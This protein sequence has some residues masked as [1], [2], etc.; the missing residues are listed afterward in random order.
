MKVLFITYLA[1]FGIFDGITQAQ[2]VDPAEYLSAEMEMTGEGGSEP[3]L[4]KLRLLPTEDQIFVIDAIVH[5]LQSISAGPA[6]APST[7]VGYVCVA[8]GILYQV[9]TDEQIIQA[10]GKLSN[11]GH[12]EPDAAEIL[13]SCEGSGGVE[14]IQ[15]LAEQRLPELESAINPKNDAERARSN[16]ILIPFHFLVV[17]L[18]GATNPE[19]SR[20]AKKLRDQVAARYLSENGKSFVAVLDDEMTKTRSRVE[21]FRSNPE[22]VPSKTNSDSAK[23]LKVNSSNFYKSTQ[24][25]LREKTSISTPYKVTVM[26]GIILVGTALAWRFMRKFN[27]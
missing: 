10:F 27:L 13:A 24:P 12:S 11:F 3:A 23:K 7:T 18:N 26:I 20:A 5:N 1:L 19:G 17:H 22:L 15:K 6:P 16:N 2:L 25:Q 9:G 4:R 21:K 14:I 8:A